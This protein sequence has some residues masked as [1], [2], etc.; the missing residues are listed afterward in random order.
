MSRHPRGDSVR[1]ADILTA[2]KLIATYIAD[3]RAEFQTSSKTQDAV[4]RQLEV[5]GEAAGNVSEGLRKIHPEV[6]WKAMRGFASFSKHEYSRLELDRIWE[7][8]V[9]CGSISTAVS[10]IRVDLN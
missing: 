5:M 1:L 6:P 2:T 4:I 9:E 8:A 10:K 3:G 7:A